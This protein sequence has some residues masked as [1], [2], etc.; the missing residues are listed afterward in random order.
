[1]PTTPNYWKDP[2]H[3]FHVRYVNGYRWLSLD[4][5][6]RAVATY[7]HRSEEVA[8][9][10]LR[11]DVQ[12]LDDLLMVT[13]VHAPFVPIVDVDRL[14]L[15]N[16]FVTADNPD[17]MLAFANKWG[18]P[19]QID[20]PVVPPFM[21]LSWTQIRYVQTAVA[22]TLRFIKPG[23]QLGQCVRLTQPGA[24]WEFSF[25]SWTEDDLM[26]THIP[27]LLHQAVDSDPLVSGKEAS[28]SN[29][30]RAIAIWGVS[31]LLRDH[32]RNS[33]IVP[34]G[35]RAPEVHRLADPVGAMALLMA[36]MLSGA[37][38]EGKRSF[39]VC[40][41]PPCRRVF[42]MNTKRQQYCCS[43]HQVDAKTWR[44]RERAKQRR[45]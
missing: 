9:D 17:A 24:I 18:L 40:N 23:P 20:A 13:E 42:L 35:K 29:M 43:N 8:L 16:E 38:P 28:A 45:R 30:A 1:M 4:E 39:A 14:E 21:V 3:P 44:R 34:S 37:K 12:P 2:V 15:I 32:T 25:Q 31:D 33:F 5:C 10:R 26:W 19:V 7:A 27:D 22:N 11:R 36:S 41:Y 6:V